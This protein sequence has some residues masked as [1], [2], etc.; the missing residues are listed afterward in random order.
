MVKK[1]LLITGASGFIGSKFLESYGDDYDITLVSLSRT[2]VDD[3]DFEGVD[4]VLHLAA[5]VHQMNGA[6]DSEY[7]KINTHLT[8][9]LAIASKS[10]GVK[11]FVFMSTV[12]VYG[13]DGQIDSDQ[14]IFNEES[15]TLPTDAYGASKLHAENILRNMENPDFRVAII[16]SPAVYGEG[17]KGNFIKLIKFIKTFKIAPFN[18]AKNKRSLC[19][20]G[21]LIDYINLIIKNEHEGIFIP[22]DKE[23]V[24]LK[25]ISL[26]IKK[27]SGGGQLL[28][29]PE[30]LL[31]FFNKNSFVVRLYGSLRFDG[32]KG[33]LISGF[34]PR[35]ST[36]Q[37]IENMVR[38]YLNKKNKS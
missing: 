28:A 27:V 13:S 30:F 6:E 9:E 14:I 33:D 16:R 22:K 31:K 20:I 23:D 4:T 34:I 5:L 21:N 24:S 12:K 8:Q 1:K 26:V 10:Y 35:Y 25:D 15:Q 2:K 38:W 37:G 7:F 11:H 32:K 19:Y 17:C 18:Y 3:I 29:V 36:N